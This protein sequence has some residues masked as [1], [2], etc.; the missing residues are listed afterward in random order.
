MSAA[1]KRLD[2]DEAAEDAEDIRAFIAST[3]WL[4]APDEEGLL[5]LH[6]LQRMAA[7]LDLARPLQLT[8]IEC[9]AVL[10]Y[11][12]SIKSKHK[13]RRCFGHGGS[14]EAC[15]FDHILECVA[16]AVAANAD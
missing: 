13:D 4:A 5:G 1:A 12:A 16:K 9:S 15:G 7:S 8:L 6:T 10:A 2:E 3:E 14:G 11:L